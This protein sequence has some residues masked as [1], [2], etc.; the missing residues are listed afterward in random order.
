MEGA[1]IKE[2]KT[3]LL[4]EDDAIIAMAEK[5]QL[6]KMEYGVIVANTGEK[7]V[8]IIQKEQN[9]DLVLMDIDLG[10][11]ID[12]T[13]AAEIILRKHDIPILFLTSHT[14]PEILEKLKKI[15]SYGHVTKNSTIRVLD[16]SVKLALKVFEIKAPKIWKENAVY[17]S[18]E[19]NDL[20]TKNLF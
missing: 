5:G 3:L 20:L 6:E 18:A 15:P 10:N 12:G 7:A 1:K 11:G 17:A 8:E 14:E 4:V 2:I 19:T 9:I 13:T 16:A